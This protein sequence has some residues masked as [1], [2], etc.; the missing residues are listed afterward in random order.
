M[1]VQVTETGGRN[2]I[3][4]EIESDLDETRPGGELYEIFRGVNVGLTRPAPLMPFARYVHYLIP[5]QLYERCPRFNSIQARSTKGVFYLHAE[6]EFITEQI[7]NFFNS[8]R[9][10]LYITKRG[11]LSQAISAFWLVSPRFEY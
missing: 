6:F 7:A 11:G 8:L 10:L 4:G 1:A 9:M 3:F 5:C 2:A